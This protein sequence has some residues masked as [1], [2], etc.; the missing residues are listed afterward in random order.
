E[1]SDYIKSD[2]DVEL[3]KRTPSSYLG[4]C[5]FKLPEP[6]EGNEI[7]E[8]L[9]SIF[10]KY[11]IKGFF[12][13]GGN[14]SMDTVKKLSEYAAFNGSDVRFIGVPKTI[15]ND[16]V[17]TDHTPGFGSAAKFVAT[18][19]KELVRD[20][21]V[22]EMESVTIVEIMGRDAGW[23]TGASALSKGDDC[24]GPAMVLLPE[25][26]F[27][28]EY[29][30]GRIAEIIKTQKSIV[31]TVSE[32]VKTADG[33]YVCE[34]GS[35]KG[36]DTFGH[37]MLTGTAQTI[38]TMLKNDLGIKTRAVELST[39]QRCASHIASLTDL[40][41]SAA[42]GEYAV[43]AASEGQSGKMALL[44]RISDDPYIC[45][46][47]TADVR[48][49]ANLAKSVPLSMINENGDHVT[50]EFIKYVRPLIEGEVSQLTVNGLPQHIKLD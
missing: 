41:E 42:V 30:K 5:R 49:V 45:V 39:L 23:L 11:N 6:V 14:D 44:K 22:Y 19:T 10:E 8:K 46:T 31:I 17:I 28:Y 37:T 38:A 13:I 9:F 25:V 35:S 21:L 50:E 4:S 34:L 20:G 16:L 24:E 15:D 1:L 18:V 48:E 7:Y 43:K 26:P 40:T 2:R 36:T 12:Y 32:G 47:D 27:D 3:L 29:V 33:K